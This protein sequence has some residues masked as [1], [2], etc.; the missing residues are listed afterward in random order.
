MIRDLY[1]YPDRITGKARPRFRN[2]HAFTDSKTAKAER[3]IRAAWIARN[4]RDLAD[5]EGE[6]WILVSWARELYKSNDPKL[7]GTADLGKP[8]WDNVAKLV[9]D[10]LNG[11]AWKDDSQ[12]TNASAMK[13]PRRKHGEGNYMHIEVNYRDKDGEDGEL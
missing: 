3:E 6:V 10:A 11:V 8:D 13:L 5:Y 1:L 7:E 4:G 12:V 9:C 2:G